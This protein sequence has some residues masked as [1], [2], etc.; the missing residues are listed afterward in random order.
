MVFAGTPDDILAHLGDTQECSR[1]GSR[2]HGLLA[3][4][5]YSREMVIFSI[6]ST[7]SSYIRFSVNHDHRLG[8]V[9]TLLSDALTSSIYQLPLRLPPFGVNTFDTVIII[10]MADHE[11]MDE[12]LRSFYSCEADS[13][14]IH[15]SIKGVF[16]RN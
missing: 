15:S 10:K 5:S 13:S 11:G 1:T 12:F 4:V 14:D 6:Y 3:R 8:V 9:V 16:L 7:C 2:E